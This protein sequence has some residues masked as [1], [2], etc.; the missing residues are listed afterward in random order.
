MGSQHP[1]DPAAVPGAQL[2]E[3][4]V[5]AMILC[6]LLKIEMHPESGSIRVDFRRERRRGC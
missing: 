3:G 4:K 5:A 1:L 6:R 2:D